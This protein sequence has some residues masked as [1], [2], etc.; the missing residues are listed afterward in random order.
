MKKRYI[1]VTPCFNES[2]IISSF[3]DKLNETLKNNSSFFT[4]IVVDDSSQDLTYEI[5]KQYKFKSANLDL[6]SIKLKFNSGHQEAIRQGLIFTK[7]IPVKFEGIIVM[8][9]DGEDNPEAILKMI[10]YDNFDIIFIERG[11][12]IESIKF[13]AGYYLYKMMFSIITGKKI[14]FG[15]F[16]LISY[17]VFNSIV[18]RKF[19]HY[20]GFLSKQKFKIETILFDRSKRI[21]GKSKMS[22]NNLVLHGMKSL[23]EYADELLFF[24]FKS[25]AIVFI[26]TIVFGLIILY[27]KYILEEAILGWAS[28]IGINLISINIIIVGIIIVGL[29]LLSIKNSITQNEV[30]YLKN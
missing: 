9:S 14:T 16:S 4:V 18:N 26:S 2:K 21:D 7:S 1:I 8:D 30:S 11:K 20:A 3:L 6:K 29:L 23:V 12:R 15:N 10:E 22:Y 19:F 5:V 27:K 13:K 17:D 28:S 25:F 24:L